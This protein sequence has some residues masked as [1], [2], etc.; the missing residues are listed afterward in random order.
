[1]CNRSRVQGSEVQGF[2]DEIGI[3]GWFF[4]LT[5]SNPES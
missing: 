3:Q 4:L 5:F 2:P 1:L